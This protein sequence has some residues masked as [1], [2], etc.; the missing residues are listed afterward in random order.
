RTACVTLLIA[1]VTKLIAPM[2]PSAILFTIFLPAS[3]KLEATPV[4]TFNAPCIPVEIALKTE[5]IAPETIPPNE[6]NTLDIVLLILLTIEDIMDSMLLHILEI[7]LLILLIMLDI[8]DSIEFQM[9]DIV[10]LMPLITL[11]IIDSI[12]FQILDIVLL[13]LF[14]T[15]E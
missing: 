10:L 11:E 12:E 9:L 4:T 13:I 14:I 6:L 15:L 2:I 5:P 1:S 7:V 8:I 3:K